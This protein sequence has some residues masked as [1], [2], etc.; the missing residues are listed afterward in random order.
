MFDL[1]WIADYP[2][3]QDF[4]EVLF[5]GGSDVNYGEYR[6]SEV[7]DLLDR[8]GVEPDKSRSINLYRQAEQKMIDDAACLPLWFGRNYLLVK[9]YVKNYRVSPLGFAMLNLVSIEK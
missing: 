2:H 7:D 5:H 4:L 1:G 3:Q 9:P 6:N 8:A